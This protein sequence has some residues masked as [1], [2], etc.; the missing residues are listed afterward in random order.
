MSLAKFLKSCD[1]LIHLLLAA[2]FLIL[3]ISLTLLGLKK[4]TRH[5]EA[6][7]V[8]NFSELTVSQALET[9]KKAKLR[10]EIIDSTHNALAAPGAVVDQNPEPGFNV[11]QNHTIFITINSSIPEQVLMPK[12]TDISIRQAQ[13]LIE[14]CGLK[15]G[16]TIYEPSEYNDLVLKA[17]IDSTE[18][19]P[20]EKMIKGTAIDLV[21]GSNKANLTN[22]GEQD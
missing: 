9:A 14:N 7:P 2:I 13:V 21:V 17:I 19:R 10:I 12:L 1:F 4:Y 11:K 22:F 20:G 3:L 5:G 15:M 16:N 18:V 8:P 6:H